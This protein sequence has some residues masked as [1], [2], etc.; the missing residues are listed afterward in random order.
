MNAQPQFTGTRFHPRPLRY[1]QAPATPAEQQYAQAI[2]RT[3]RHTSVVRGTVL[4]AAIGMFVMAGMA[5]T[6][7]DDVKT[8]QL[9]AEDVAEAQAQAAEMHREAVALAALVGSKH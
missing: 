2:S 7:P 1:T 8:A 9:A 3:V 4:A 5:C 6:G